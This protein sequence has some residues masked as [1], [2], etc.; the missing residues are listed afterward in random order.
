[1]DTRLNLLRFPGS[2]PSGSAQGMA[3]RLVT[4]QLLTV[5]DFSQAVTL[6]K[7]KARKRKL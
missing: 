5:V 1:M 7:R 6:P 2:R 3:Q 4:P